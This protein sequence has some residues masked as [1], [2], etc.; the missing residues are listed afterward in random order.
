MQNKTK[1]LR[2]WIKESSFKI[3]LEDRRGSSHALP[4]L[5]NHKLQPSTAETYLIFP[6][7]KKPTLC[8]P[9]GRISPP[10]ATISDSNSVSE[11]PSPHWIL[12]SFQRTWVQIS[13]SQF[14][15]FLYKVM[16]LSFDLWTCLWCA[17]ACVSGCALLLSLPNKPISQVK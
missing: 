7:R 15:P 8:S 9:G 12:T 3:Q 1:D 14:S 17:I 5:L 6:H 11:K 10:L 16:S 2:N 4:L 13:P